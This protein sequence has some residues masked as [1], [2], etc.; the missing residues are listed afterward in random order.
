VNPGPRSHRS[1]LTSGAVVVASMLLGGCSSWISASEFGALS[2]VLFVVSG[3]ALTRSLRFEMR[4]RRLLT[5]RIVILG[6]GPMTVKLLED[7]EA[8]EGGLDVVAGVIDDRH[9]PEPWASRIPWLGVPAQLGEIVAAVRPARIVVA[10][11]DRRDRLPLQLLLESRVRGI[12]VEDSMEFY[13]RLTGKMAI[14]ELKPSALIHS[15]GFH[16]HGAAETTARVVSLVVAAIGLMLSA[17]LL[18]VIAIAIKLDS[19]GPVLFV[20]QR[21]GRNGQPFRLLKFRTM[22]PCDEP[23]SEWA[24]DNE[25][26]ITRVGRW[27][28]RFRLDEVP[29]LVNVLRGEM[30]LVGPRPHPTSNHEIF[31]QRIAYYLLRSTVRPGVTGWAQ[32]RYG[33]AN[34]LEEETEKMRYDLYYI[35]NRS[36]WLDSR[37]LLHTVLV[38]LGGQGAAA[39]RPES[40]HPNLTP[41]AEYTAKPSPLHLVIRR[42]WSGRAAARPQVE[43][44]RR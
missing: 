4:Q 7:I 14:E 38:V 25:H 5:R 2:F 31:S 37:I 26:R 18:A 22:R 28:R 34:N 6:C 33:Y 15:A 24:R 40:H 23:G 42:T 1:V 19:R 21:A 9:L 35:K 11:A 39:V 32:V 13:E 30:N 41:S 36:L 16:N 27:L 43:A 8:I 12:I 17:P 44:V 10:V 3:T 20:Q 29:Q